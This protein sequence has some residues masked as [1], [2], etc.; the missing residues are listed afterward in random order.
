[1][2][3]SERRRGHAQLS[4]L[5]PQG[6]GPAPSAPAGIR[7]HGGLEHGWLSL[8]RVG[9]QCK[10]VLVTE[11]GCEG[12]GTPTARVCGSPGVLRGAGARSRSGE[13]VE[14]VLRDVV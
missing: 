1:M 6:P 3:G 9:L 5:M 2:L 7:V 10:G 13:A 4:T 11:K 8:G 14:E 12:P